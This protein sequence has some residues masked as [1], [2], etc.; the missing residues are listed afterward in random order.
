MIDY[1]CSNCGWEGEYLVR[2]SEDPDSNH[3]RQCECILTK[4]Q[5]PQRHYKPFA[6]YFDDQLGVEVTG[7]DHRRRIMRD[8]QVDFK[9][10]MS[11][12]DLTARK[13]RAMQTRKELVAQGRG[14]P[15]WG[16]NY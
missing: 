9:D 15:E 2:S 6:P 3:C 4:V 16:R 1:V 7:R 11:Q 13:D 8:M 5:R 14:K 10:H 12:G